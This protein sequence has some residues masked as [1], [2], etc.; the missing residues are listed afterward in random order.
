MKYKFGLDHQESG[1]GCQRGRKK[2]ND[3]PVKY[4]SHRLQLQWENDENGYILDGTIG[5]LKEI[6]CRELFSMVQRDRDKKGGMK[7]VKPKEGPGD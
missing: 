4:V 1:F 6:L 7:L 5:P 3:L 2:Q